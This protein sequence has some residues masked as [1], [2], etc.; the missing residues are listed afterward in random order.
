[1]RQMITCPVAPGTDNWVTAVAA[2]AALCGSSVVGAK[3]KSWPLEAG[4]TSVPGAKVVAKEMPWLQLDCEKVR[5][6]DGV[7]VGKGPALNV[8]SWA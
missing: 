1:M 4:T 3:L 6:D 7:G 5:L 8:G 2:A